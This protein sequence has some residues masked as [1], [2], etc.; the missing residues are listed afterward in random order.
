VAFLDE[1]V[2]LP[3]IGEEERI[4]RAFC[5]SAL[6]QIYQTCISSS[7]AEMQIYNSFSGSRNAGL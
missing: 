3:L 7:D 5:S 4:L 2:Y 6:W 1:L